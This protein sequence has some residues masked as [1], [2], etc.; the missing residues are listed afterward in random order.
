MPD[1][2]H[3]EFEFMKHVLK[4]IFLRY[5]ENGTVDMLYHTRAFHG[6]LN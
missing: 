5:Q 2:T 1:E 6:Q 3:P 4:K